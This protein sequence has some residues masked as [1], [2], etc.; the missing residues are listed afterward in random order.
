VSAVNKAQEVGISQCS[1]VI[2]GITE[3][4]MDVVHMAQ[5]LK[6]LDAA[7]I[8]VNF[9]NPI[10]GTKLEGTNELTPMY[11]LKV[12]ALSRFMNPTKDVRIS[13]GREVTLRTLQPLALY[14]ANSIF[15]GDYLTT[16]GRDGTKDHQM[17][18]DL[19]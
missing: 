2:G 14:A 3:A 5:S 1:G 17:L 4:Q 6:E 9:L 16:A 10:E 8:P 19:G 11:C 7:S 18:E 13:G 12:L 15:I